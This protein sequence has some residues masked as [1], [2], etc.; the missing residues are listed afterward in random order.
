MA[1]S[2]TFTYVII[3]ADTSQ[4]IQEKESNTSGGLL[5][6]EL[7]QN[8]K[9]YFSFQHN[10]ILK[11]V[12]EIDNAS[13][14]ERQLLLQNLREQ[15]KDKNVG[16]VDDT[17]LIQM[18]KASV[19][20]TALEILALTIPTKDTNYEGVSMYISP[21]SSQSPTTNLPFNARA[22][23]LIQ[24]CNYHG[25][26]GK[27]GDLVLHG[28]VFIGRYHDNEMEDIWIRKDFTREDASPNSAWCQTKKSN[29][30]I[31]SNIAQFM[32]K[33]K[34]EEIEQKEDNYTWT[35]SFEEI[36]IK[37]MFESI[38][39]SEINVSFKKQSLMVKVK[40][41]ILVNGA[42]AE[43]YDLE[44][45][46]YTVQDVLVGGVKKRELCVIL[47]KKGESWWECAI[48]K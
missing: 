16:N 21:N 36:E 43:E 17:T 9:E 38:K 10:E 40:N 31:N 33:H 11:S 24:A 18:L 29:T 42:T 8:A 46:T 4:P 15:L 22:T 23:E 44:D 34:Q 48:R 14:E 3:P 41:D 37:F 35:Q 45:S 47:V 32:H 27:Q 7:Q 12:K 6:D 19:E 26:D 28:D 1:N 20:A 25:N 13:E 39:T 30:E 5:N 2:E